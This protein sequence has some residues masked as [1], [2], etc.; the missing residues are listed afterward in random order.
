MPEASVL[1]NDREISSIEDLKQAAIDLFEFGSKNVL[2]KGGRLDGPAVDILYDGK[3][4]TTFEAPRI[5]TVNT[6]AL[7]CSYSAAIAANLAKG[8]SVKDAVFKAKSFITTTMEH[9]FSYTDIV[10]PT[11]HVAERKFGEAYET[12]SYYIISTIH[13]KN[14]IQINTLIRLN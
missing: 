9:G 11:Y 3:S 14:I 1:L 7:S 6:K 5:D 8:M 13:N 10:G 4:L 12:I 2:V